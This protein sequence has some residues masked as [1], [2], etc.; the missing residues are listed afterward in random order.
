MN[1]TLFG[2]I[3][4]SRLDEE[5]DF[6]TEKCR[7]LLA[8]LVL[9]A[10]NPVRRDLL[11]GMLWPDRPAVDAGRNLRKTIS[12][13]RRSVGD[14]SAEIPL[15]IVERDSVRI[16][17]HAHLSVDVMEFDSLLDSC[18]RHRHRNAETCV[19][20]AL[21]RS[22]ACDLY[23]GP[24]LAGISLPDS[25]PFEE[26]V[27]F[28][29]STLEL[30][31]TQALE[32]L[33][34][35]SVRMG[36]KNDVSHLIARLLRL[37]PLNE[38]AHMHLLRLLAHDG[39]R[40]AAVQHYRELSRRY[41][42]ELGMELSV[43]LQDTIDAISEDSAVFLP[44]RRNVSGLPAPLD[45]FVGRSDELSRIREWVESPDG[46]LATIVGPGGVGK[47][48]LL[49]A[50]VEEVAT[51][52]DGGARFVSLE[53]EGK[54]WADGML[55]M[56]GSDEVLLAVDGVERQEGAVEAIR[57]LLRERP[58]L[59]IIAT[60]RTPTGIPGEALMPLE[61][62]KS[63][64]V[65]FRGGA[66]RF[67]SVALFTQAALRS[68][69]SFRLEMSQYAAVGEICRLV[70]GMPL[71]I[72]LAAGW[73]ATLSPVEIAAEL[74]NSLHLLTTGGMN[75]G[76]MNGGSE[77]ETLFEQSAA[78]LSERERTAFAR[79][80]VF[81][82]G[83][84]REAAEEVASTDVATLAALTRKSF[85]QRLADQRY[86]LHPLFRGFGAKLLAEAGETDAVAAAH[87]RYYLANAEKRNPLI[88]ATTSARAFLWLVVEQHNLQA[89][90][91]WATTRDPDKAASLASLIHAEI[92]GYGF[93][94]IRLP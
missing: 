61:G 90:H 94:D 20:C 28:W 8:Y 73:V 12:R 51:S 5:I 85:V 24:F 71:A 3:V 45:S 70:G 23:Q 10:W 68:A 86:D 26:W 77:L 65:G 39:R 33:I 78:M 2:G 29:R 7:A 81:R 53:A 1:V 75:G 79:L 48:R 9:E 69:P 84:D 93:H 17:P 6:E 37:D 52:F 36:R 63:P 50:V 74:R 31:V 4:A 19:G 35:H 47:T 83:F 66:D 82:G 25:D 16:N 80:S 30:R 91:A 22:T 46:R 55:A 72:N 41:R 13:L 15:L 34:D 54:S 43:E 87:C 44:P 40:A 38:K 49:V 89:A 62:M 58:R 67:D 32:L 21:R 56:L 18:G 59:V 57:H 27:G 42:R 64:P 88:R 11:A 76:G 60:S 14:R 92:R